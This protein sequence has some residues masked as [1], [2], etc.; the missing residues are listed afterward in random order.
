VSLRVEERLL[1]EAQNELGWRGVHRDIK[2]SL[3]PA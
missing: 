3:L 2:D 1:A